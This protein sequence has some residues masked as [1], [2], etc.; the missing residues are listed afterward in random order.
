MKAQK[1]TKIMVTCALLV[2][3]QVILARFLSIN[4]T[5]VVV[6]FSFLAVAL[7][8]ILFGPLWALAVGA[9]SDLIGATLFPFGAFFP[10]FTVTAGLVGLIYG[11]FLHQKGEG[12]HG[13]ALWLRV[14][15]ASLCASLTRLV[16]NSVWLYIMYGKGLFG[17]LPARFTETICMVAA[18][19]LLIPV[20]LSL[21]RQL[22]RRGA[23]PA[24]RT[25]AE[26]VA[27][28][29]SLLQEASPVL[30]CQGRPAVSLPRCCRR[31]APRDK[32]GDQ[33]QTQQQRGHGGHHA[34]THEYPPCPLMLFW[35]QYNRRS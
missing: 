3:L 33:A 32:A 4:T 10:G 7:S 9:V 35:G 11:L 29:R 16:L 6:N 30:R 22:T 18:Q 24:N 25:G 14:V 21:S 17:M 12:F 31:D 26:P 15:G 19:I 8:G 5:F 23:F 28:R 27:P 1:N 13:R 20:L 2:A 34:I